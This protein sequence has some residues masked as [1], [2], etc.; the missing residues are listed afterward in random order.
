MKS[1][2]QIV[3]AVATG[4][5]SAAEVLEASIARIEAT[6]SKVN[7]FTGKTYGRARAEAAAID[8]RRA[9]GEVLPALAGVP[10]A[11]KNLFDMEGVVTLAGSKINRGDKPAL[12]DA[13]LVERMKAA[14][15]VLLGGLN[16]DE[17][18]YGFTTEN[19]HYGACHNPHDLSR[20]AGGSSG[21]SGAA[22]AAHAGLG[23]QWLHPRAVIPV[24]RVGLEADLRA[25]VAAR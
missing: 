5:I 15:A 13:F 16:M 3:H 18:A 19:S 24:R 1:L 4:Q 12:Q 21:G 20:I 11:V 9:R 14:G 23:H 6:D 10:Y 2:V 8:A 22:I 25:A 7:A 17:Y